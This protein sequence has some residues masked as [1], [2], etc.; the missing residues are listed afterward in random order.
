MQTS[1]AGSIG[2]PPANNSAER[3]Y[4]DLHNNLVSA[5]WNQRPGAMVIGG[6]YM[7][8]QANDP[9]ASFPPS[10]SI[11]PGKQANS[12]SLPVFF[13][14]SIYGLIFTI[15]LRCKYI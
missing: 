12:P 3:N 2:E 11:G 10:P 13:L 9:S 14:Y 8:Q 15:L 1:M 4:I 5:V 7:S 6:Y